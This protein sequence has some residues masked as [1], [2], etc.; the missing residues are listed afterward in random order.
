MGFHN[1]LQYVLWRMFPSIVISK[2]GITDNHS[3]M[4][5]SRSGCRPDR[6]GFGLIKYEEIE[7]CAIDSDVL[8][9]CSIA[10]TLKDPEGFC[11]AL[12]RKYLRVDF[13]RMLEENKEVVETKVQ[14]SPSPSPFQRTY[15]HIA[16]PFIGGLDCDIVYAFERITKFTRLHNF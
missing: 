6:H 3:L 16:I 11:N 13:K 14:A 5:S 4:E 1:I 7:S 2:K 8:G 9:N 10:I 12:N 15:F